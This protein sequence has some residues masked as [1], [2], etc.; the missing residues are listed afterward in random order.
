MLIDNTTAGTLVATAN[1]T[2]SDGYQFKGTLTT[3]S[4]NLFANQDFILLR[5]LRG[6]ITVRSR[7]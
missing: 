6:E 2:M 3:S 1:L 5:R 4:T 7:Q